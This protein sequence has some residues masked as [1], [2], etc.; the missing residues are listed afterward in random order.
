M[1]RKGVGLGKTDDVLEGLKQHNLSN[2]SLYLLLIL[3]NHCTSGDGGDFS[4]PYREALIT[5]G[6]EAGE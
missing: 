4:N 3:V 6:N 5:F 2:Q 1:L